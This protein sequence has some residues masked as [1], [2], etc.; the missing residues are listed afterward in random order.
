MTFIGYII[1]ECGRIL[2]KEGYREHSDLLWGIRL[3]KITP[4]Y[5]K[6]SQ[7]GCFLEVVHLFR[8]WS[9]FPDTY[10]R[11]EMFMKDYTDI[12]KMKSFIPQEVYNFYSI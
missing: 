3:Y 4:S 9:A 2:L 1:R 7:V 10:F 5:L 12:D 8:Y 6:K 11:F